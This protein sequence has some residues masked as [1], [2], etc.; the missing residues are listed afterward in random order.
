MPP[1]DQLCGQPPAEQEQAEERERDDD[2][3]NRRPLA[4]HDPQDHAERYGAQPRGDPG[5]ADGEGPPPGPGRQPA[6][7]EAAQERP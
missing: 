2:E 3:R 6:G 5:G 1:G 4:G 7:A